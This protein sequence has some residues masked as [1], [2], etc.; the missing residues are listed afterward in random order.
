MRSIAERHEFTSSKAWA[1]DQQLS[2]WGSGTDCR[3]A[4]RIPARVRL[5]ALLAIALIAAAAFSASSALAA[6]APV[7]V[8][9]APQNPTYTTVEVSGEIDPKGALVE[10]NLEV[11][12]DGGANW[13]IPGGY[14]APGTNGQINGEVLSGPQGIGAQTLEHLRPGQ[15]YQFRIGVFSYADGEIYVSSLPNPEFQTPAIPDPVLLIDP[16]SNISGATAHF[17]GTVDPNPPAG[18]PAISNV[19]WHFHCVPSCPSVE[20]DTE[21]HVVKAAEGEKEVEAD[22]TGLEPNT[23][24]EVTLVGTNA[25]SSASSASVSFK[26][27]AV[28]PSATTIPAVV[29]PGGVIS[30]GGRIN[31]RNSATHWWIEYG[32][33]TAYGTSVPVSEDADAGSGGAVGTFTQKIA[34]L[35]AETTYHFQIVAENATGKTGGGDRAFTTSSPI[36]SG[37]TNAAIRAAQQVT[38]P[39]CRAYELVSRGDGNFGNVLRVLGADDDGGQV[40]YDATGSTD[41]ANSSLLLS[42]SVSSRSPGGWATVSSDPFTPGVLP[43]YPRVAQP[44]AISSDFSKLLIQSNA[45]IDPANDGDNGGLD[46]YLVDVDTGAATMVSVGETRPDTIRGAQPQFVAAS[47]DLSR[48]YSRMENVSLLAGAPSRT[49]DEWDEGRLKGASVLP[50]GSS[51]VSAELHPGPHGRSGFE[52][53]ENNSARLAHGGP[54]VV[55]DDGSTVFWKQEVGGSALYASR[56]G[57]TVQVNASQRAGVEASG[58]VTFV[59]ASHDGN[60]V[61]FASND[62][63]TEAA[64]PGGGIYRYDLASEELVVLT[65]EAGPGGLG[66]TDALMSDDASHVYFLATAALAPGAEPGLLN[67]Y[68]YAN[69]QTRFLFTLPGPANPGFLGGPTV[70]RASRD[71]RYAVIQ[72]TASLGGAHVNGHQA[73][74]E[75]D[76]QSGLLSCVSCRADGSPSQGDATLNDTA[77]QSIAAFYAQS[78]PRNISDDG[79]VFFATTDRLVPGDATGSEGFGFQSVTNGSDVYEYDNGTV[80][81][82]TTG[83]SQYDSY[84]ADNSDDGRD[85][86]IV[87]YNSLLSEDEDGGLA[88]IYD[89]R[90]D[91]GYPSPPSNGRTPC[92]NDCQHPAG[93][94]PAAGVG[95]A[96]LEGDESPPRGTDRIAVTGSRSASGMSVTLRV[97]VGGPGKIEL[98]GPDVVHRSRSVKKGGIYPLEATLTP[99]ARSSLQRGDAVET[100]V[101]LTFASNQGA[102]VKK[103]LT[104]TFKPRNTGSNG[105][106]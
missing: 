87:T 29:G 97:K 7:I 80:S 71:G 31:A 34:G 44:L 42:S 51:P 40:A 35:A 12:S 77:P 58:T 32:P 48:I 89:V 17:S 59:G 30:L 55:S 19:Q 4:R 8:A 14:L 82:L 46:L 93:P 49:L 38:L 62:Q 92:G 85:A 104:V 23:T 21:E 72:T 28:A 15:T 102:T 2:P 26:T 57:D 56:N 99:K 50:G 60:T 22:A 43:G 65:P 91:A 6:E 70:Q 24:Y 5:I 96:T 37:C 13:E 54:H 75:Y 16:V 81:L 78:S 76:D 74:Y 88:D 18:E 63:L 106:K 103:N 53:G 52:T 86:F 98:F 73:L 39:A 64:T 101:T 3:H 68:V 36:G 95:S 25:G 90:R 79:R 47:R 10:W 20:N 83:H 9:G 94:P 84:V 105:G 27:D 1:N 100:T 33:T 67:V 61:Y 41:A 66:I 11:S 45:S 69:G